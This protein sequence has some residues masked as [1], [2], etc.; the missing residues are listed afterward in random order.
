[1]QFIAGEGADLR[2]ISRYVD[3]HLALYIASN[4]R[5]S[6]S[7]QT[8]ISNSCT[9]IAE[10]LMHACT[11]TLFG[12]PH[13]QAE[14]TESMLACRGFSGELYAVSECSKR[15]MPALTL[16]S[17]ALGF[18]ATCRKDL[19]RNLCMGYDCETQW[20]VLPLDIR[21]LFPR[22]CLGVP[23]SYTNT[24]MS[25]IKAN[26]T[27]EESCTIL[28]RI[29]RYDL[30]AFLAVNKLN[31]FLTRGDQALTAKECRQM[32]ADIQETYHPVLNYSAISL[33]SIFT[34]YF[35][36][37]IAYIYHTGGTWVKFF[38]LACMADPEYQRELDGAL[39]N[40]P[41]MI[42]KPTTFIL[43]GLWI[44]SRAVMSVALPFFLYHRRKDISDLAGTVG[45]S[46]IIQK[47]NRLII[48]SYGDTETAFVH[49][50]DTGKCRLVF[51]QGTL[52]QEPQWGHT[53]ITHYDN[54]MRVTLHQECKNGQVANEFAYE[55]TVKRPQ[56]RMKYSKTKHSRIPLSRTCAS[57]GEEGAK[58]LYNRKGHI[59][60]GSYMSHGN[61]VRFKYHYRKNA[62]YDDGLLRA[63]F[64]LPHMSA[65]VSWCAPP[66]RHAEK[67]E[68]WIPT[69][70]VCT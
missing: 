18:E 22:R 68:R 31:N 34:E 60:S 67:M 16:G 21:R 61:L 39:A 51:Y 41:R 15:S 40:T 6:A 44:Y 33:I 55:Y 50:I 3:G 66:V 5:V 13:N 4:S 12:I 1:M 70:R 9:T 48:R 59:E 26:V 62:K 14:I 53:R 52:E 46:L 56:R 20:D 2:A 7:G 36:L 28:S 37:P 25:W 24:E 19:L 10:T 8:N 64:V 49:P 45:G 27:A 35:R 69:P 42:A 23:G 57:G 30:G 58:A 29:A 47:K 17:D 11:E 32:T 43:T 38:V 63:E 54:D 65:N